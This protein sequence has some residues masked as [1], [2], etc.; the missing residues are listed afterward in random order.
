MYYDRK[1]GMT[2]REHKNYNVALELKSIDANG[3][4]A[5]YASVF[6]VIDN[7]HDVMQRGAFSKTLS[8]GVTNIKL[9]WQHQQD[10]PIGIFDRIF[11]DAHGL[12][13]EGRL[14]LDVARA[15]EAYALLKAGALTGLS[16]GYSPSRY[17][18]DADTG[19]RKLLEVD[20]WE[21]SLVTFPANEAANVTVVKSSE[22]ILSNYEIECW[23]QALKAGHVLQLSNALDKAITNLHH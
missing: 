10:E 7:Q 1:I 14:L 12:Y 13:V 23:E 2:M 20:L 5:G 19:V 3:R 21:V 6:N 22:P 4:F 17:H 18:I 16:I 15:K 11:E 8:R 9:L